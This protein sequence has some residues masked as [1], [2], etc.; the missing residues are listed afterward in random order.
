MAGKRTIAHSLKEPD[1]YLTKQ[2]R[3]IRQAIE[4]D[5]RAL[6]ALRSLSD[7]GVNVGYVLA[8]LPMY[9]EN[10]RRRRTGAASLEVV[11]VDTQGSVRRITTSAFRLKTLPTRLRELADDLILAGALKPLP[12]NLIGTS[13]SLRALAAWLEKNRLVIPDARLLRVPTAAL[14]LIMLN[15]IPSIPN[16]DLP[17]LARLLAEVL[18]VVGILFDFVPAS[19]GAILK[20]AKRT[21]PPQT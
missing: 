14:K 13:L 3:A 8:L 21:F 7:S 2:D 9:V 17:K 4:R 19:A 1:F 11:T 20:L 15:T 5:P 16:P 10:A 6:S 18:S 12:K